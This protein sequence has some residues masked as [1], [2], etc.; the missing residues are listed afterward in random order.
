MRNSCTFF[1]AAAALL[2]SLSGCAGILYPAHMGNEKIADQS[3]VQQI[4]PQ[5][6]TM[7]DVRDLVGSPKRMTKSSNGD[8]KWLYD[9]MRIMP[10]GTK[11]EATT[12]EITFREGIVRDVTYGEQEETRRITGNFEPTT[13][14]KKL[15]SLQSSSTVSSSDA[16][17]AVPSS[18]HNTRTASKYWCSFLGIMVRTDEKTT[19]EEIEP[20]TS[21]IKYLKVGDEIIK[22]GKDN[23]DS[24]NAYQILTKQLM[25]ESDGSVLI[26]IR[27]GNKDIQYNIRSG[28][29]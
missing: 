2:I 13:E 16:N 19:I 17:K 18:T 1:I 14:G 23:V 15:E 12:L 5:I 27:R 20:N 28:V 21:A 7:R 11:Y 3:I 26:V 29:F 22:V 8:T 9:Y 10:M 25:T 4:K 6:S 24:N